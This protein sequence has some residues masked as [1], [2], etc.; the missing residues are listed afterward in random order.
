MMAATPTKLGSEAETDRST[1]QRA[2][3]LT[4]CSKIAGIMCSVRKDEALNPQLGAETGLNYGN[5]VNS[6][7]GGVPNRECPIIIWIGPAPEFEE[8]C[9]DGLY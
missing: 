2:L 1:V 5:F 3:I 6:L 9:P 4:F 7:T 8:E